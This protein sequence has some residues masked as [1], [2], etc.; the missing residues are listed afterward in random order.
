[1]RSN[2]RVSVSAAVAIATCCLALIAVPRGRVS[3]QNV[4][5][6]AAWKGI[7]GVGLIGAEVGFIV[8][9][10]AGMDDTWPYIVFP[11][12]GGIGGGLAGYFLVENNDQTELAIGSVALGMA[13]IIPTWVIVLSATTYDPEDEG[14]VQDDQGGPDEVLPPIDEGGELM[15]PEPGEEEPADSPADSTSSRFD[16]I[17]PAGLLRVSDRGVGV[18][19]PLVTVVPVFSEHEIA[20]SYGQRTDEVRLSVFS[21]TF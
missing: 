1:M 8:P 14:I 17:A 5:V 20:L 19:I 2:L 16:E 12:V 9:A 6:D 15:P 10:L 4:E 11:A 18:G 21:G 7:T 3:A 13:M